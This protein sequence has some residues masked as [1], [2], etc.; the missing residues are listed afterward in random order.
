MLRVVSKAITGVKPPVRGVLD[1]ARPVTDIPPTVHQKPI[2]QTAQMPEQI[3]VLIAEDNEVNQ[4][5]IKYI[6]EDMGL[7]FKIAPSG[8]LAV[9]KWKLFNPKIILM[10]I[11]MPD[12][13]GYEATKA[14]RDLEVKLNRPR[15]PIVA[16]TAHALKG[17]RQDCLDNDMDDYISKPIAIERVKDILAKWAVL[18]VLPT[19]QVS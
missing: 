6:M 8:R 2:A 14:I 4:M 10:D 17:N 3:D 13:N 19:T 16:V 5:F 15:T 9:D 18:N 1:K 7:S 12:W 11:S